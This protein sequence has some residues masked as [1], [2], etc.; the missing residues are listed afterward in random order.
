MS[1]FS[2]YKEVRESYR[3]NREAWKELAK[4]AYEVREQDKYWWRLEFGKDEWWFDYDPEDDESSQEGYFTD[5]EHRREARHPEEGSER[6]LG[7][8]ETVVDGHEVSCRVFDSVDNGEA[9]SQID[10]ACENGE[11]CFL[12]FA[13]FGEDGDEMTLLTNRT[14]LRV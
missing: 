4:K 14:P 5:S 8:F 9:V 12:I 7:K 2:T 10:F 1:K 6:V 3:T 11:W 13:K